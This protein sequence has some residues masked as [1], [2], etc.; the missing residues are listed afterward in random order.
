MMIII[1]K[2]NMRVPQ[3]IVQEALRLV[4]MT[5]IDMSLESRID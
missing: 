1:R 3:L 4:N 2:G 5:L